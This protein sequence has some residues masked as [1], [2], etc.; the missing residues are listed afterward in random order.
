VKT[1]Y[2]NNNKITLT[3]TTMFVVETLRKIAILLDILLSIKSN[4]PRAVL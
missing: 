3:T 4:F 1:N 2:E